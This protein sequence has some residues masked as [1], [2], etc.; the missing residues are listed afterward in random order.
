[1]I[2]LKSMIGSTAQQFLTY[3]AHRGEETG[4]IRG[5]MK[6][7]VPAERMGTRERLYG[8]LGGGVLGGV[9]GGWGGVWGSALSPPIFPCPLAEWISVDKDEAAAGKGK[10]PLGA[11]ATQDYAK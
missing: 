6:V 8:E 5:S 3:L 10:A 9:L 2:A 1:M 7:R 11:R 4:N